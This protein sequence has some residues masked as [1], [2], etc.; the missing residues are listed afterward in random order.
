M[1]SPILTRTSYQATTASS[2]IHNSL[3]VLT[4]EAT[5]YEPLAVSVK[6]KGKVHPTT[7][8]KGP[9][10]GQRYSSSLPLSSTLDGGG[11]GGQHHAPPTLPP[12]KTRY[13]LYRRLGGPQ[14][15]SE[16]VRKISPPPPRF[17]PRNVQPVASRYTVCV[18]IAR[19]GVS[20]QTINRYSPFAAINAS[21]FNGVLLTGQHVEFASDK[22]RGCTKK[23]HQPAW[24]LNETRVDKLKETTVDGQDG[25]LRANIR[26]HEPLNIYRRTANWYVKAFVW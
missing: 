25:H 11:V 14:G 21:F 5:H 6:G 15:R 26:I 23:Y 7:G 3:N 24:G 4:F 8:H 17:D 2:S 10:G 22:L 16:R 19:K 1:F 18:I 12:G 20:K 9:K 13:P